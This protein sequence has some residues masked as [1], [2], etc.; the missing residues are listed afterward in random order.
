MRAQPDDGEVLP[1]HYAGNSPS[2]VLVPEGIASDDP[3]TR[4]DQLSCHEFML[5]YSVT[6]F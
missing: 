4:L 2:F 6:D 3:V 5:S 1:G